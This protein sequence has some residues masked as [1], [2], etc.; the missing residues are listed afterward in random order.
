MTGTNYELFI[1]CG[2]GAAMSFAVRDSKKKLRKIAKT[3]KIRE[4]HILKETR[5]IVEKGRYDE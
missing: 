3:H 4:W 5:E 1:V 2:D